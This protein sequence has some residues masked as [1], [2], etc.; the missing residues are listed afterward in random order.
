MTSG[1]WEVLAR[2]G[3]KV[4]YSDMDFYLNY[5]Q[6]EVIVQHFVQ[7]VAVQERVSIRFSPSDLA[8]FSPVRSG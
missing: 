2:H 3:S 5:P 6:G 4:G 1:E 8:L 7:N